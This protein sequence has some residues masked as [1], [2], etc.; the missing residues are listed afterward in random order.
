MSFKILKDR[1]P[2]VIKNIKTLTAKEVKIGVPA[3]KAGRKPEDGEKGEPPNNAEIG[4]WMEFGVPEKNIPARPFL[5]PGVQAIKDKAIKR[6]KKAGEAAI[7]GKL[8]EVANQLAS[9]GLEGAAAVQRKITDGPF[10]QLSDRTIQARADRG[11]GGA[12]KYLKQQAA[13][14]TPDA[15]LVRPL[16][17]TGALRQS[18]SFVVTDKGK[19]K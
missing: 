6:L 18:I 4:M 15:D 17:D 14:Q 10:A 12:K 8:D 13:G 9:I 5:V 16:M 11:R 3:D 7:D 19:D 1:L 2:D